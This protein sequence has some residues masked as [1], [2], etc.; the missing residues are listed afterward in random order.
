MVLLFHYLPFWLKFLL[1]IDFHYHHSAFCVEFESLLEHHI[2]SNAD[3]IFVVDFSI[4][5]NKQDDS[6]TVVFNRLLLNFNLNQYISFPTHDSDRIIH[7]IITNASSKLAIYPNLIESC[8]S[9]HKT[10]YVDLDIQKPVAQKSYFT[11][12]PLN[13]INFTDF[14]NDITAAFSKFEHFDFNS[15]CITF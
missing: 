3:I 15:I 6:N 10:V 14:N 8:I 12:H 13:K 11:F 2:A 9:D 7:V 1:I 4:H 5:I